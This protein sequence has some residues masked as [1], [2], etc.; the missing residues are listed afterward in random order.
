[1]AQQRRASYRDRGIV[2]HTTKYGERKL[3]VHLLTSLHG[4]CSYVVRVSKSSS[5]A[6]FQP[7]YLIEFEGIAPASEGLHTMGDVTLCP[8]L[9]T[10]PNSPIKAMVVMLLGELLYRV[11]RDSDSTIHSFTHHSI[12][13]FDSLSSNRATA[14]FHLYYLVNLASLLG[15]APVGDYF[16]G[17][18]FDIKEGQYT[19]QEPMHPLYI[20]PE[21]ASILSRVSLMEFSELESMEL[22]G[23]QRRGFLSAMVDY[24]GYHNESIYSVRSI[25][26]FSEVL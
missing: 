4:R 8:P 1:M 13:Q 10:I 21:L 7:M 15:Y 2:L 24:F 25:S 22:S 26:I 23:T 16:D 9:K 19:P 3:I 17:D 11:V 12:L 18:Y 14:N 20:K 5:R 6:L